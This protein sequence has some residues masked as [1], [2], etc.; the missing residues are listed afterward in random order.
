MD[1]TAYDK[2]RALEKAGKAEEA[3]R[4]FR[5]A[6]AIDDV[7]RLLAA[8]KRY[9]EAGEALFS[10]LGVRPAQ[11]GQLEPALK[12]RAL[13]AAIWLAKGAEAQVSVELFVALGE[14]QRAAE[15]LQRAGDQVG[16]A[17]LMAGERLDAPSL[18]T[19]SKQVSL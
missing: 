5:E 3:L 7:G 15:T 4:A 6:G 17:R 8:G 18:L 11:V 10:S 1:R 9:R 16:A 2:A 12:K 19:Q 13:S 14:R